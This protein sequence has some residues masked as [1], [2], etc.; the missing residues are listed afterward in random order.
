[1]NKVLTSKDIKSDKPIL[2]C[3][4]AVFQLG[5]KAFTAKSTAFELMNEVEQ[6]VTEHAGFIV[7]FDQ[8]NLVVMDIPSRDGDRFILRYAILPNFDDL[9]MRLVQA[10]QTSEIAITADLKRDFDAYLGK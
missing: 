8:P 1:M 7:I 5:G 3:N 2:S 9:I 10:A 6:F 4:A